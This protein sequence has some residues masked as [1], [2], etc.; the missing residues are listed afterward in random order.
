[1]SLSF[2]KRWGS[3]GLVGGGGKGISWSMEIVF[4]GG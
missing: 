1:M 3:T 2:L 4:L